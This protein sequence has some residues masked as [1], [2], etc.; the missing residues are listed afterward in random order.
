MNL[1]VFGIS[2]KWNHIIFV[3]LISLSI[4]F[5]RVIHAVSEFHFFLRL[6]NIP[7]YAHTIV[8]LSIALRIDIW[9]LLTLGYRQY[10]AMNTGV[11]VSV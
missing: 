8:G 5:S 7:L 4:M 11:Q 6:K 9:L 10:A 2:S 1:P 3:W